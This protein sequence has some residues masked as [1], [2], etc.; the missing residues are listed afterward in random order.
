[1][2][3]DHRRA[4]RVAGS[5]RY[6]ICM[7]RASTTR[8]TSP[9]SRSSDRCS[10]SPFRSGV[11]GTWWYGTPKG[12]RASRDPD[13][14]TRRR[15]RPR[16]ARRAASARAGRAHSGR[17]ATRTA[18]RAGEPRRR[19]FASSSR[20]RRRRPPSFASRAS[21]CRCSSSRWNSI[22][23]KNRPPSGSVE[24]W[25]DE[26]MFAPLSARSRES[27]A[28][29]PGRSG[30]ATISRATS[31]PSLM[32]VELRASREPRRQRRLGPGDTH[33]RAAG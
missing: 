17:G 5:R 31:A 23:R 1:M 15:R 29:I 6:R 8:S 26:M 28:M 11:T 21:L 19:Q 33:P 20:T 2:D 3:V 12:G 30:H 4:D 24:Y 7:Y 18:R 14:S 16:R 9:A 32:T 25:S 10:A 22:R 27:A 13:G